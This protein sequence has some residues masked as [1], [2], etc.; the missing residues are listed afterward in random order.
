MWSSDLAQDRPD[1]APLP[2]AHLDLVGEGMHLG[3][4]RRV[5]LVDDLLVALGLPRREEL[6]ARE[7]HP[8]H[9]QC[10]HSLDRDDPHRLRVTAV[11]S[12][13]LGYPAQRVGVGLGRE[14]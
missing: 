13:P 6:I 14:G 10:P 1:V 2:P 8:R 11:V 5:L 3:N 7:D 4:E 12:V 9:D